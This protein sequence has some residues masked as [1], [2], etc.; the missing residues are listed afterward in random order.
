MI[1]VGFLAS[2]FI[3]RSASGTAQTARRLVVELL[4]NY[5]DTVNVVLFLKTT[6]EKKLAESEKDLS[7]ARLEVFPN[8]K[9]KFFRSSRQFYKYCFSPGNS[10][11]DIL[12][13]SVPR[14]YPFFWKFPAHHFVCTFHA[15]GDITVKQEKFVISKNIYNLVMKFS[16][17]RLK[18]IYADSDFARLEIA[19]SYKIPI[20][21]IQKI[22]LGADE[23]TQHD[24][25]SMELPE[26]K[27]IV[28]VGRWQ[29]YKNLHTVLDSI[30]I[31]NYDLGKPFHVYL[32]GRSQQMGFNLVKSA[33]ELFDKSK[34]TSIEYL[35]YGSLR[36]LYKNASVVVHPSINEGFGLPAF[37]AFF[38]GAPLL[39]H[40]GT[41]ASDEL[42]RE[43]GVW[44]TNMLDVHEIHRSLKEILEGKFKI[45]LISRHSLIKE[46][47]M[48]WE[49]MANQY[50]KHYLSII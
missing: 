27:R 6:E 28:I 41:P 2:G 7:G 49:D 24:F 18:G 38:E 29:V 22:Y 48:T 16:W 36:F 11:I 13:F 17:R 47:H 34:I 3:G 4:K 14:V 23:L 32:I 33:I 9:G 40:T 1:K 21:N 8:V 35:D 44:T 45:D 12:H 46:R 19:N 43:E 42:G 10:T 20:S 15:A 26:V 39:V 37:E 25:K 5:S 50:V 30:R 31:N